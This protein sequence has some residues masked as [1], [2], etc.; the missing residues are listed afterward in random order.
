MTMSAVDM[1]APARLSHGGTLALSV[2]R[3]FTVGKPILKQAFRAIQ[4][5]SSDQVMIGVS[6][7]DFANAS[8]LELI[9]RRA[10]I[11]QED[12]RMRCDQ[13]LRVP[14]CFQLVDDA[15]IGCAKVGRRLPWRFPRRHG[16]FPQMSGSLTSRAA[17]FFTRR[18]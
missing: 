11:G 12:G 5:F 3:L 8:V 7:S 6:V 13:Q 2:I 14:W 15:Q 1:A 18:S 16:H 10:R 9:Q 17:L 4:E